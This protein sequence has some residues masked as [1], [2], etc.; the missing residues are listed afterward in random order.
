MQEGK[1]FTLDRSIIVSVASSNN[2]KGG[3]AVY[4]NNLTQNSFAKW[5]PSNAADAQTNK[6]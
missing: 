2:N 4:S 6:Q 1:A 5:L 3:G